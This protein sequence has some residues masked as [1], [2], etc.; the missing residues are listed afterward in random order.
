MYITWFFLQEDNPNVP[1]YTSASDLAG[2]WD[3]VTLQIDD[4]NSTFK[5][6]ELL[7]E[8][9]WKEVPCQKV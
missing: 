1:F 9:N 7:R 8:N 3:L 6:I 2:F 4:I 5:E